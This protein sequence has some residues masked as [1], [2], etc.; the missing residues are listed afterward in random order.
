VSQAGYNNN[1]NAIQVS[2]AALVFKG[3]Y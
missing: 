2:S 1:V 3:C